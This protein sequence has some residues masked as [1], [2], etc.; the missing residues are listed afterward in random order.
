V[1]TRAMELRRKWMTAM[2][3]PEDVINEECGLAVDEAEEQRQLDAMT[4]IK[5]MWD[6]DSIPSMNLSNVIAAIKKSSVPVFFGITGGGSEAVSLLLK[7][8]GA[9]NVFLGAI[10]PYSRT[11]LCRHIKL[12]DYDKSV[13]RKVAQALATVGPTNIDHFGI[14]VTCSL[15]KDGER[16]G[17]DHKIVIC[18]AHNKMHEIPDSDKKV[19]TS[20][21]RTTCEV[22]LKEDRTRIQEEF[23]VSAMVLSFAHCFLN[24]TKPFPLMHKPWLRMIGLTDND[25]VKV[26]FH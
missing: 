20:R 25:E 11:E 5:D 26:D 2:G 8:G 15:V 10:V 21:F 3:L 1:V 9:S 16:D 17:R 12:F 24:L 4:K 6:R 14:G 19:P 22:V 13:S 18:A 7:G 23:I